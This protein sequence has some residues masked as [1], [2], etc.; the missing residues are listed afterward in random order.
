M[1][2]FFCEVN[3]KVEP[4]PVNMG[5]HGNRSSQKDIVSLSTMKE[6]LRKRFLPSLPHTVFRVPSPIICD[7]HIRKVF[8]N[9]YFLYV[10]TYINRDQSSLFPYLLYEYPSKNC[11]LLYCTGDSTAG[12]QRCPA[13]HF[14]SDTFIP[15][16][17]LLIMV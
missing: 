13:I 5:L 1:K 11:F 9:C 16:L 15:R 2:F 7:D 6:H 17:D 14:S 12:L 4:L 3:W 10:H 8:G